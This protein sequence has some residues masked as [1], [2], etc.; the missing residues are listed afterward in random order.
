MFNPA[1]PASLVNLDMSEATHLFYATRLSACFDIPA[2]ENV[3]IPA[4]EV[5]L[6]STGLRLL[7]NFS[8]YQLFE[9]QLRSRSGLAVNNYVS[10]LNAPATIDIDFEGEIK[11]I[12]MNHGKLEYR[13]SKGERIA[14]ATFAPVHR[15]L[16]VRVLDNDRCEGGFGSSGIHL[17]EE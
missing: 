1:V 15:C 4:G 12:L 16:S 5:R 6:V 10:V 7:R 13:V 14:Q 3:V 17:T 2:N 8:T 9:L 11:V